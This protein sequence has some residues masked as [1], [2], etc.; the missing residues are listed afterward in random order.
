MKETTTTRRFIRNHGRDGN[1][2]QC[3]R[4]ATSSCTDAHQMSDG[5]KESLMRYGCEQHPVEPMI[6][7]ADGTSM[8]AKQY[9][10]LSE[11]KQ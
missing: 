11:A 5:W 2:C 10:K 9:E 7:F 3:G 1:F 4:P 8:T 6:H